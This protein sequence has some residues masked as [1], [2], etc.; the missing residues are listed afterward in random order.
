MIYA[1]KSLGQNFL[2]S[3]SA[4][5][6]IIDAGDVTGDDIV[7]EIGPGKGML[8][9]KLLIFAGKVIAIEKD[10]TLVEFLKEKF[11]NEI[12]NNKLDLVE[13]DILDF[14][15]EILE[16]YKEPYKLVANIP[17]YITGQ[18]IRKFLETT[19]QP[20]LM[21]LMLQKEV[22]LRIVARDKRSF[23][24]AQGKE[25]ILSISV[26][27]YGKPKYI[28]MVKAGSFSP[29]PK[30]DSAILLID[31]ISKEFFE[32]FSEEDFF[33]MVHA[34]F[35]SKRKKLTILNEA[36]SKNIWWNEMEKKSVL[37]MLKTLLQHRDVDSG[38]IS[39]EDYNREIVE[40]LEEANK[41]I[42]IAQDQMEKRASEW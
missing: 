39:T 21:V 32:D 28:Q 8:T 17:Y 20:S 5:D 35:K 19:N 24:S 18:L 27:A 33:K 23:D 26:K 30:V 22:A 6:T 1:K 7:L 11:V 36:P 4:V 42:Y 15:P 37:L 13:R 16:F 40:A 14:D 38:R 25:S 12:K 10:T 9:K 29:K 34:G 41:G 3:E 31:N 2:T